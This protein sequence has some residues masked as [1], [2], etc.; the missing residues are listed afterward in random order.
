[1]T[2]AEQGS[3]WSPSTNISN[4]DQRSVV[5]YDYQGVIKYIQLPDDHM[6]LRYIHCGLGSNI[7]IHPFICM[8][9]RPLYS[10]Y[11]ERPR[12]T[13]QTLQFQCKKNDFLANSHEQ[14]RN[15]QYACRSTHTIVVELA[16]KY[17]NVATTSFTTNDHQ[18]MI[19]SIDKRGACGYQ[20]TASK[21]LTMIGWWPGIHFEEF[22]SHSIARARLASAMCAEVSSTT[23]QVGL[24]DCVR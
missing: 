20:S 3:A 1:M 9:N 17:F 5:I 15:V 11:L 8:C 16:I 22:T 13:P 18:S 19:S 2:G 21:C 23:C 24:I 4:T 7:Q 10:M 12:L 6:Y 14:V